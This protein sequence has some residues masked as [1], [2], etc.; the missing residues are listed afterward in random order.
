[1]GN[2]STK[3]D[4]SGGLSEAVRRALREGTALATGVLALVLFV[5]LA[6]Y[7]RGDPGPTFTGSGEPVHNLVGSVGAWFADFLFFLVGKPAFLLPLA[8]ALTAVRVWRSQAVVETGGR[9]NFMVRVAGFVALL[10]C[11]CALAEMHWSPGALRQSAGGVIGMS[12]GGALVGGLKLLGA[13]LL[14][15][16]VWAGAAAVA[17]GI[18]WLRVIDGLGA[19]VWRA[20]RW[21][22]ERRQT[23]KVMSEGIERKQARLEV[24]EAEVK[25]ARAR[26]P[27]RIEP[28]PPAAPKSERAEKERQV[29]LFDPP[30]AGELPAL[31]LLDDPGVREPSYS[32][33]ALEAMSRL[34][35]LKLRDFGVEVEV[36]AVHPGPVITRFELRP[37]PGVKASA[38][39]ALAKDLARAL[40]TTSV[41]VVEVIPGKSVMGLE[42]PN[43]K[44]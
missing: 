16:A 14:C 35:E 39:T 32:S 36:V 40:S 21:L 1:L 22:R 24:V 8:G 10:L 34:V 28:P 7:D 27:P 5:A 4:K 25:R 42:V 12:L 43:E 9:V 6:S 3:S 38:I 44:R 31:G 17:F 26:P 33:E 30:G 29:P 15:L 37:A 19:A 13:T 18:S 41:R 11:S 20:I 23:A 2:A